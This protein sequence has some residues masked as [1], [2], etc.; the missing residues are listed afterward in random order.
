MFISE[1]FQLRQRSAV[2][3]LSHISVVEPASNKV[4]SAYNIC[5]S[6]DRR[7]SVV[8]TNLVSMPGNLAYLYSFDFDHNALDVCEL[9]Y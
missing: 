9:I 1:Y 5:Y 3:K 4:K 6:G 7:V 8:L 2:W